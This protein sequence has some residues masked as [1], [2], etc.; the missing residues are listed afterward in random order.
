MVAVIFVFVLAAVPLV[1]VILFGCY[2]IDPS[3]VTYLK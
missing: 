2:R 3:A 1:I